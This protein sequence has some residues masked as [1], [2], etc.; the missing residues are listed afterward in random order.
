MMDLIGD[1][2]YKLLQ[3]TLFNVL[4]LD[5][6]HVSLPDSKY[7]PSFLLNLLCCLIDK[8]CYF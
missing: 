5:D 3:N 1:F 2:S 4:K 7:K 6:M 8:V